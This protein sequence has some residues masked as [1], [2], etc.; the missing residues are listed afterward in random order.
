MTFCSKFELNCIIPTYHLQ[1]GNQHWSNNDLSF[2]KFWGVTNKQDVTNHVD[3]RAIFTNKI[4][5]NKISLVSVHKAINDDC[6][7]T[8]LMLKFGGC[9]KVR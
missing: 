2:P 3:F 4:I 1:Y 5:S 7:N 6:G 9:V 8:N